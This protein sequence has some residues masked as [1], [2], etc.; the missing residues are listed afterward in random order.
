M[1]KENFKGL[2]LAGGTGSRLKPVTFGVSKHLLPVYDKP[3]IY[4]PLSILMLAGIKEIGLILNRHDHESF[5][6]L[7]GDG[8]D[9]GIEITYIFQDEPRGIADALLIS[10][11]FINSSGVMMVLGDNIFYGQNFSGILSSALDDH[12]NSTIFTYPVNNPSQFGI[13]EYDNKNNPLEAIEKPNKSKSNSAITGLYIFDKNVS[14]LA[15]GVKPSERGELEITDV[16]NIYLKNNE[17]K[18]VNLGRGFAWLDTGT[19]DS[20]IKAGHF[21]ETVE[22]KQG[23]KIACLE[24]IALNNKWINTNQISKAIDRLIHTSYG[25][26]LKN[27]IEKE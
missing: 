16:I 4:Y 25:D 1:Q 2:I 5:K 9:F 24:E 12:K 13:L 20:L 3:M 27:L 7:L 14:L 11:N 10:K 26:Y 15:E 23:Y 6:R 21:V 19:H 18:I 22:N 17:T 8:S